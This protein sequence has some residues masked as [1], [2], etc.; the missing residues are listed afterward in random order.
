LCR[1]LLKHFGSSILQIEILH[2][3]RFL[4]LVRNYL[5]VYY[6]RFIERALLPKIHKQFTEFYSKPDMLYQGIQ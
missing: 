6:L 1:A 3:A 2:I 4:L 5:R